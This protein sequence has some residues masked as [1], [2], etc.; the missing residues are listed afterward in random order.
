MAKQIIVRDSVTKNCGLTNFVPYPNVTSINDDLIVNS[1]TDPVTGKVT[2]DLEIKDCEIQCQFGTRADFVAAG[3]V[4]TNEMVVWANGVAYEGDTTANYLPGLPGWRERGTFTNFHTGNNLTAFFNNIAG[5]DAALIGNMSES[6]RIAAS[7]SVNGGNFNLDMRAATLD[8]SGIGASGTPTT[9][10]RIDGTPGTVLTITSIVETI[11][12]SQVKRTTIT[13]AGAHGFSLGDRVFASS[14]DLVDINHD[15]LETRGQYVSVWEIISP[16]SFTIS[17]PLNHQLVT[18][19]IVR[20]IDAIENVTITG[21]HI[22][23]AGRFAPSLPGDIGILISYG[24]NCR[25]I[26][27]SLNNVDYQ[28]VKFENCDNCHLDGMFDTVQGKLGSDA[29]S[30]GAVVN[31]GSTGCTVN[32]VRSWNR[33]HA[34]DYSRNDNPGVGSNSVIDDAVIYNAWDSA[35]AMHGNAEGGIIKNIKVYNCLY[36][37]NIR[38]RDWIV[39]NLWG[40]DTS[41]VLRLTDQPAG[42]RAS[43]IFGKNVNYVV[44]VP[45]TDVFIGTDKLANMHFTNIRG[46]S[47]KQTPVIIENRTDNSPIPGLVID[48]VSA[49]CVTPVVF[50]YGNFKGPVIRNVQDTN[51]VPTFSPIVHISGDDTV[52]AE[53]VRLEGITS[54]NHAPPLITGFTNGVSADFDYFTANKSTRTSE[55]RG[56]FRQWFL[57]QDPAQAVID[58]DTEGVLYTSRNMNPVNNEKYT[59]AVMFGSTD[60]NFTTQTPKVG[61]AIVGRATEPYLTDDA[62]GMA[63][64]FFT[65]PELAGPNGNIGLGMSLTE[66]KSLYIKGDS[67]AIETSNPPS[68]ATDIG[69]TGEIRWDAGFIYVCIASNTWVR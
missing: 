29:V 67:V 40:E 35:I 18:N 15:A 13:T 55:F 22:I 62:S 41:E 36:G 52:F 61:A 48:G 28:G 26:N 2:Y 64:D 54:I 1:T 10:L 25:V 44:R 46:E 59:P 11:A 51:T 50:L 21:G 6:S 58:Q 31:N 68:S 38:Q 65:S 39:T 57:S 53:N 69:N 17:E 45:R 42:I 32:R 19:P 24:R 5:K 20:S 27:I 47:V 4:P 8:F 30:Y 60:G 33:K 9:H 66:K 14:D 49:D 37:V 3:I 16:T 34:I 63:I 56:G 23:G 12:T 7:Y 43:N